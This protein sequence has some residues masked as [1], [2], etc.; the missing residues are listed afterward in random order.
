MKT[1][2]FNNAILPLIPANKRRI[3]FFVIFFALLIQASALSILFFDTSLSKVI[4]ILACV[5][6]L[7]FVF[8][9][10]RNFFIVLIIYSC[11]FHLDV[12]ANIFRGFINIGLKWET[13]YLMYGVLIIFWIFSLIL[14]NKRIQFGALGYAILI[15][16]II[17]ILSFIHGYFNGYIRSTSMLLRSELFPQLMY[18]SFFIFL[19][20]SMKD[21]RKRI[22]FDFILF[23]SAFIGLQL[24]YA[25]TK[26]SLVAFTRINTVTV[27]ISLISIPYV[28]GILYYSKDI[29]RKIVSAV[30]LI[31]I[32]FGVLICL[33]RS[34]WLAIGVVFVVSLFIFFY[35]RGFSI[36][37]ILFV[38]LIALI[39]CTLLFSIAI[40]I[41]TRVT[42]GGT[43]L[44]LLKRLISL[45]NFEY[46]Q[47]DSSAYV[48]ITEIKQALSK[49]N[50]IQWL[51]GRGIG[52][53]FYSFLRT[54]TKSYVDNC[55]AWVMWK[56]GIIGLI[57]F[58]A[59]FV[60]FFQ[61]SIFL[62]KKC[63]KSEENI[64]VMT[65]F[66]NIAGL[67]VVALGNASL[68]QFRYIMIWAISMGVMETMYKKYKNENSAN[69]LK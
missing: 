8:S 27:H 22:L 36:R 31:P 69:V 51:I 16:A 26:N 37:R 2:K 43:I 47:V 5:P 62:L 63:A 3:H 45:V 34:L 60:I 10:V 59:I 17:A 4:I 68:V 30:L 53:T 33:Q 20:T 28:L 66:L 25:Y 11:L 38:F 7:V 19:T 41:L 14:K 50:G 57:S 13:V 46:L 42:A 21:F 23:A 55:Y 58:L 12:Y 44:V 18:L 9:S 65:L 52:D 49:I 15:Y 39:A 32:C 67:L 40:F 61:R 1:E 56:M 64:Y 6:L 48:R 24:M 29:K 54:K 35:Q